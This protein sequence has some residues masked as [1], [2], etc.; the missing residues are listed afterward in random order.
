MWLFDFA[1]IPIDIKKVTN[2]NKPLTIIIQNI[3]NINLLLETLD[4]IEDSYL[5]DHIDLILVNETGNDLDEIL[6]FHK[7]Q[8]RKIKIIKK[9]SVDYLDIEIENINSRHILMI[10]SGM[11]ISNKFIEKVGQYLENHNFS[12]I[13]FPIYNNNQN[14]RYIFHQLFYSFKQAYKCSLI[15]KNLYSISEINN[16]SILIEKEI[17]KELL[18][19]DVKDKIHQKFI[20]DSDLLIYDKNTRLDINY[21]S[22]IYLL[23]NFVYFIAI[24]Q[25]LASPSFLYLLIIIIKVLPEFYYKYAYYNRLKIKFPKVEFLVYSFFS[26]IYLAMIC[27]SNFRLDRIN[28]KKGY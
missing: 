28:L 15:N 13:F 3:N 23:L 27:L 9:R 8:F 10:K 25:F 1:E 2:P 7:T 19:N 21:M 6:Q 4:S 16:S 17:L 26:P 18:E 24:A 11:T 14:K 22:M 5:P 12:I 20:M